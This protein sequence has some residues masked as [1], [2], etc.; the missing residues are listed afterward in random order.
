[1][2]LT[3]QDPGSEYAFRDPKIRD[4]WIRKLY[5]IRDPWIRKVYKIRRSGIRGS[6]IIVHIFDVKRRKFLKTFQIVKQKF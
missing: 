5:K 3:H 2:Q 4:P 1:M 6:D